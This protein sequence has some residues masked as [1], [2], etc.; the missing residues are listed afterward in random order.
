[1]FGSQSI[2]RRAGIDALF[3]KKISLLPTT[4]ALSERIAFQ[5]E[6]NPCRELIPRLVIHVRRVRGARIPQ[7]FWLARGA[8]KTS[9]MGASPQFGGMFLSI[10][11]CERSGAWDRCEVLVSK[12]APSA[13]LSSPSQTEFR[14]TSI[15]P[16]LRRRLF[17]APKSSRTARMSSGPAGIHHTS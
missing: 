7:M 14:V 4:G 8:E 12:H 3:N 16:H 10:T 6:K 11:C 5:V 13:S 2:F 1:M 9:K 15:L 17:D